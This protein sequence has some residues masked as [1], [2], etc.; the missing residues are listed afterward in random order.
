MPY[1]VLRPKRISPRSGVRKRDDSAIEAD[2]V[3]A[4]C[5]EGVRVVFHGEPPVDVDD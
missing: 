3:S 5:F 4:P 2:S 1:G